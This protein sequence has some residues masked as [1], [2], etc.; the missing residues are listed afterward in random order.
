MFCT[1]KKVLNSWQHTVEQ[2][3]ILCAW[4]VMHAKKLKTQNSQKWISE[5]VVFLRPQT[6]TP[7]GEG[8]FL[9]Q[10]PHAPME[11]ATTLSAYPV[12][13][14]LSS[15]ATSESNNMGWARCMGSPCAKS[16]LTFTSIKCLI[17]LLKAMT[18]NDTSISNLKYA[19]RMYISSLIGNLS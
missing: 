5:N 4:N 1:Q 18:I 12:G 9:K 14:P 7:S 6:P 15:I 8:H 19:A 16:D 13:Q 11:Q 17:P 3:I 10:G 2:Q